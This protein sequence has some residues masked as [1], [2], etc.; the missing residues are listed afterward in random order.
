MSVSRG[1][2]GLHNSVD[3][4]VWRQS[5]RRYGYDVI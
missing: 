1:E 4:I 5:V 2:K 3:R